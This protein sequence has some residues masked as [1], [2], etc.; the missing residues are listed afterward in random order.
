MAIAPTT[1]VGT[2]QLA[3]SDLPRSLAYYTDAIGLALL[4]SSGGEATLGTG[5]DVLLHLVEEPGAR[6]ADG[7]SGLFHFALLVPERGDLAG[8]LRHAIADQV[9]LTGASD[10]FV[11][12]A[13]YLRDPDHHGIEIYADRPRETW[14]GVADRIGTWPLDLDDLLAANEQPVA[15]LPAGTT[16]GPRAPAR[17]GCRR[18]DPLL[19]RRRRLRPDRAARR[20]G[21]VPERRRLPPSPRCEHV[22]ESRRGAGATPEPHGSS[23]SRSSCPTRRSVTGSSRRQAASFAIPPGTASSSSPRPSRQ[24]SSA[25]RA[26]AAVH[27]RR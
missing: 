8:W 18:D 7:Y 23:T 24:A 19:S 16:H 26:G 21:C 20:P 15:E 12:E 11:S 1:T 25:A 14:E 2:V 6:P 17:R 9:R 22:G 3:V 5:G 10:H 27:A 13:L 4:A